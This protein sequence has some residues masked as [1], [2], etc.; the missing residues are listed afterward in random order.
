MTDEQIVDLFFHRSE[1]A[2]SETE[3]A[4]GRYFHYIAY[5]ILHDEEDAKEIVNDA[6]LK[7]WNSIP[8]ERPNPLKGFLGHITRQLAINRLERNTAKKRGGCQYSALLDELEECVP[9][10]KSSDFTEQVALECALNQFLRELPSES[11]RVFIR[12]YWYM[13]SISEIAGGLSISESKVK[14]LLMR[15]RKRL[16]KHLIQEGFEQ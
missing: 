1:K 12:R 16:K 11:R 6:Y 15:L 2:I 10:S 14:S 5:G 3:T 13:N 7:A 8:P 9:D 4:Y